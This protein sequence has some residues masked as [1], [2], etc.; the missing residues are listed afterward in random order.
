MK[1]PSGQV[2]ILPTQRMPTGKLPRPNYKPWVW[3]IEE[4]DYPIASYVGVGEWTLKNGHTYFYLYLKT[5]YND[6]SLDNIINQI[7]YRTS[8]HFGNILGGY[9]FNAV[10]RKTCFDKILVS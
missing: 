7:N 9:Q 1:T 3:Y 5:P 8:P 4:D 10:L 6:P 2:V